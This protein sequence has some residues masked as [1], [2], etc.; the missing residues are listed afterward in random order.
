MRGEDDR[1]ADAAEAVDDPREP[2]RAHVRL[3]VDRRDDVAAGLE[4]EP[5]EDLRALACDRRELEARVRHHVADDLDP[6][7]DALAAR[8]SRRALVRRQEQLRRGRR[9]R[10]G[11]APPASRGRRSAARP[12]RARPAT[13]PR[14]LRAGERR[15]RVA[16]DEDPVGPLGL[17][18]RRGSPAP[19][20]PCRPSAGRAGTPAR[21]G[22]ARRRR[23]RRAPRPSAARCAGRPRRCPRRAARPTAGP[24]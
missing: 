2:L 3:A 21:A 5:R 7:R 14:R 18:D 8:G 19:S 17:D 9:P 24:T 15:V 23:R 4:A 16:V 13:S 6:P 11:S 20:P 12:R 22:R 10:S 1:L